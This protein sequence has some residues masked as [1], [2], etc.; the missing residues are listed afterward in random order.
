ML[1]TPQQQPVQ[2]ID[3]AE[4]AVSLNQYYE[5]RVLVLRS[6][7]RQQTEKVTDLTA[8]NEELKKELAKLKPAEAKTPPATKEVKK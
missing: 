8:E 6:A 1:P 5:K 4:E 7:L 3:M 2:P